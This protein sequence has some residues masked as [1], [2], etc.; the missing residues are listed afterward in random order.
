MGLITRL[1]AEEELPVYIMG[2][3]DEDFF[4]SSIAE[5]KLRRVVERGMRFRPDITEVSVR[6]KRA[7]R[8]GERTRYDLTAR[9]LSPNDQT[10]AEAEGWDLLETF[11]EL[12]STLERALRRTKQE[13][14][15]QRRRRGR[16]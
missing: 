1:R 9:A 11:D 10:I 5:D 8:K 12:C 3:S 15:R 4:E 7:Q 2:L 14:P 16:K 13:Q 6:I